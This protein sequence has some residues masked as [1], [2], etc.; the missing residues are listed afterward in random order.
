MGIKLKGII[1]RYNDGKKRLMYYLAE[2]FIKHG[3]VKNGG[4]FSIKILGKAENYY[5]VQK[6]ANGDLS[7]ISGVNALINVRKLLHKYKALQKS[8]GSIND[9]KIILLEDAEEKISEY[10]LVKYRVKEIAEEIETI[11]DNDDYYGVMVI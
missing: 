1:M 3:I 2:M 11:Y 5:R 6:R 4:D 9:E 8:V 7:I 10:L